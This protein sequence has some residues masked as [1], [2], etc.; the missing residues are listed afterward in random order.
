VTFGYQRKILADN[1][2]VANRPIASKSTPNTAPDFFPGFQFVA[3][4]REFDPL[5]EKLLCTDTQ[6]PVAMALHG[7]GGFGKATLAIALCH[8]A[9]VIA[10][11]NGGIFWVTLGEHPG[12][13]SELGK[14]YFDLTGQKSSHCC[15]S[16]SR[17][18]ICYLRLRVWDLAAGES[19]TTLHAVAITPDGRHVVSSSAD[20]T[21][22]LGK[23]GQDTAALGCQE[24]RSP[25]ST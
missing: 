15:G 10:R 22:R 21:H 12:V 19:K 9:Q 20:N 16:Y 18:P 24:R 3:R 13:R 25:I 5:L 2:S 4:A 6:K 23:C 1:E 17:R 11:F 14:L 7:A 8:H